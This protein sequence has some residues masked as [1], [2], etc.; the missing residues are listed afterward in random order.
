MRANATLTPM[1]TFAAVLECFAAGFGEG[2]AMDVFDPEVLNRLRGESMRL[3]TP[4][5]T[6]KSNSIILA[7]NVSFSFR[8]L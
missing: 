7:K 5:A 2:F 6:R 8:E 3:T 1:P 4:F